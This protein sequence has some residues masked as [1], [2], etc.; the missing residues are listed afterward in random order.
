MLETDCPYCD[1]RPT[2]ASHKLLSPLVTLPKFEAYK[3]VFMPPS[4]KPEKY[5][6]GKMVKGRN[7]P[8]TIGQVAW[9]ISALK[10]VPLAQVAKVA[11]D[12]TVELFALQDIVAA[13]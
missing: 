6:A 7:E 1:V 10:G 5:A 2:H 4:V 3:A 8:C 9:C 11:F 13:S 12:N